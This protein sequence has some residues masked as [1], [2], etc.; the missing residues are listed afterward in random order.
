M[1]V[2]E[3]YGGLQRIRAVSFVRQENDTEEST[4][5]KSKWQSLIRGTAK[6]YVP[7]LC[8]YIPGCGGGT[9]FGAA[10]LGNTASLHALATR[11]FTTVFAGI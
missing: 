11:N 3:D 8:S 6:A 2:V 4:R 9:G 10:L 5:A 7:K 1:H